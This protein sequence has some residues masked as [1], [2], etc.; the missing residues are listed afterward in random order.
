MK[1]CT[2]C[3]IEK[4]FEAFHKN[5]HRKD[6]Y[7]TE[8]KECNKERYLELK[9]SPLMQLEKQIRSSVLLENKLLLREGK[10]LC[11]GCK[12]IFLIDSLVDCKHCKNCK[13][14]KAKKHYTKNKDKIKEQ[15]KEYY[16]KNK[17][18][19][20][21]QLKEYRKEYYIKNK[22]KINERYKEYRKQYYLKKKLEK[23][24]TS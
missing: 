17:D 8:C 3:K 19:I 6:G 16:T 11:G 21:E 7:H 12:E 4:P 23:E 14:D 13:I 9:R 10:R 15:Q 22:N 2:K 20:N 24:T 1:T 18:K 5:K